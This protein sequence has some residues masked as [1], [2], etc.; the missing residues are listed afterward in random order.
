MREHHP[1]RVWFRPWSMRCSCGCRWFPC[2][3]A[4]TA[5]SPPVTQSLGMPTPDGNGPAACCVPLRVNRH[6]VTEAER[7]RSRRR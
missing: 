6:P 5:E 7:W 2:P 1:V 3:D 4:A